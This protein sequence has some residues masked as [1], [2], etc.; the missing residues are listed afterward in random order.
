MDTNAKKSKTLSGLS[1]EEEIRL[2]DEMTVSRIMLRT[3]LYKYP[4]IFNDFMDISRNIHFIYRFKDGKKPKLKVTDN[5]LN[6]LSVPGENLLFSLAANHPSLD[7]EEREHISYFYSVLTKNTNIFVEK[8]IPLIH[9]VF[10]KCI[11]EKRFTLG[12]FSEY[13]GRGVEG[14]IIAARKYDSSRG[15]RFTTMAVP[16]VRKYILEHV[17]KSYAEFRESIGMQE[18]EDNKGDFW[19]AKKINEEDIDT[20]EQSIKTTEEKIDESIDSAVQIRM[21]FDRLTI[22]IVAKLRD[23]YMSSSLSRN[24]ITKLPTLDKCLKLSKSILTDTVK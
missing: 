12:S 8:N 6:H 15:T 4:E 18:D 3:I 9:Y 21:L 13:E 11:G 20:D 19:A 17:Q 24:I 23:A 22:D 7:E 16:W 2:S 5:L 14:L 10:T 1:R